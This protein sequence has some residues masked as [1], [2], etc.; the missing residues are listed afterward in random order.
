[1]GR[2]IAGKL[3]S[4]KVEF[5]TGS[6]TRPTSDRVREA[7]FGFLASHLQVTD[8]DPSEQL[9][10]LRF[11]DLYAGSGVVGLEAASRGAQVTWVEKAPPAL[12][13]IK[14]N[15]AQLN[16]SGSV[17]GMDTERFLAGRPE[18]FN[19]AW[20]DPPYE[21]SNEKIAAVLELLDG[22][23]WIDCGGIFLV[24]RSRLTSGVEFPGGFQNVTQRRYGDTTIYHGTKVG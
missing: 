24:E 1:M 17:Y 15:L 13:T 11:L 9:A 8:R 20:L 23:G 2:I 19:I 3:A 5:P 7:V 22:R 6:L 16:I 10:G 18:V 14:K 21:E 4:R 12:K